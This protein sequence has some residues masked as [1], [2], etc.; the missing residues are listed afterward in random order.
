MNQKKGKV[1]NALAASRLLTLPENQLPPPEVDFAS[2]HSAEAPNAASMVTACEQAPR[3]SAQEAVASWSSRPQTP[4]EDDPPARNAL[5][6][7]GLP[8]KPPSGG[9][10][11]NSFSTND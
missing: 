4:P 11:L 2:H 3:V 10:F 7:P 1:R 8:P 5:K 6:S 9:F